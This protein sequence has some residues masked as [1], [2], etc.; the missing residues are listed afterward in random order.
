MVT[1]DIGSELGAYNAGHLANELSRFSTKELA[2]ENYLWQ[3]A[4]NKH[5]FKPHKEK[6]YKTSLLYT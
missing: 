5:Y 4:V 6:E 3:Q 2:M 1:A